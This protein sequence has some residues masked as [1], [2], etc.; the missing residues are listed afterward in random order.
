MVALQMAGAKGRESGICGGQEFEERVTS[1]RTGSISLMVSMKHLIVLMLFLTGA[2]F[3][4][5][6]TTA[7]PATENPISES[8]NWIN[9]GVTGGSS[10][11]G[12][13]RTTPGL[14]F[15]VSEPTQ[16]GDPTAILT[17]KWGAN[18]TVEGVVHV[19]SVPTNCCHEVEL[20]LRTTITSNSI[21]GYEAY[22]SVV[23]NKQYCNIARW[24]GANGSYWNIAS[25]SGVYAADGDV[26]LATA[27]GSNPTTITLYKNGTQIAQAVDTGA[28]G[29]GFGAF[30]PWTSGNPGIGFFDPTD[31]NW[32]NF[33]FSSFTASD[34]ITAAVQSA[35]RVNQEAPNKQSDGAKGHTQTYF[36]RLFSPENLPNIGLLI[37]GIAGIVV[38]IGTLRH[39]R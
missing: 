24:N 23:T 7:F 28:A 8:T 34:S 37:A 39:L 25:V 5:T 17:G 33:G 14:A 19:R 2:G 27:T 35:F 31:S 12:N 16:F 29:G 18:Q 6:Y 3:G 38:A 21:T 20:R 15:G 30:G 32:S 36:A 11:W 10:L 9:G 1:R 26:L 13:V 4:R 22:C